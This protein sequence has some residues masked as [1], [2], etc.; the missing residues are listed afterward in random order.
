MKTI[1]RILPVLLVMFMAQVV[2]AND[3]A[4]KV[5]EMDGTNQMKFTV[6][7]IEAQPGQK[8]TVKLTTISDF[9]KTA[10]A[11]NFVLLAADADVTA[12]ARAS[13]KASGNEYIPTDADMKDQIIAYTGL[14]GGGE[15]VEVT[16]TAPEESGDYEYICSFPGHYMG[17]MKGVL[18]VK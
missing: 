4:P 15:T 3:T 2:M 17:G 5:I 9:P 7:N 12:V 6:T 10:M 16:F 11:H 14:A 8:I 18:T 13:A 1:K